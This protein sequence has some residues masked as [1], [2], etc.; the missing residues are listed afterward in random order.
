[1]IKTMEIKFWGVRGSIPHSLDTNGWI[2]HIEKLFQEFF[3]SGYSRS[4][5]V[6]TFLRQKHPAYTG[7]FGTATTCVEVKDNAQSILIDGGSGIKMKSDDLEALQ[8][9]PSEYHILITHFHF[10]HI[11]GLPFFSPNFKKGCKVHYYSVQSETEEIVRSLFKKPCFPV[12]FESLSAEIHFH[13]LKVYEKNQINGFSVTPYK[14]D[15]PDECYG[16]KIE[17]KSKVYAH[18]VDN[19]GLRRTREQLGADSG[20]FENVDLLYFD[21]QYSEEDMNYKKGWG[22]GTCNRGFEICTNFSVKQILFTHHDPAF[23]IE[24]SWNQKKKA[25]EIFGSQF[26]KINSQLIWDFAYDGLV[27][28]LD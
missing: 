26:K 8:S 11:M 16:F 10:D 25:E 27:V 6:Q 12:T 24:D 4:E 5:D 7:G 20:L 23:S 15:H 17:K 13:K 21:A 3:K 19:E 22:H 2:G 9:P 14:M 18:A 28:K 1:M